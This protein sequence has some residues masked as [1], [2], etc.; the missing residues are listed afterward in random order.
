MW[1]LDLKTNNLNKIW[2]LSYSQGKD[3]REGR[4]N[5]TIGN[6]HQVIFEGI[7]GAGRGDIALDD[8]TISFSNCLFN[9]SEAFVNI[10]A[11]TT[12]PMLTTTRRLSNTTYSWLG[13]SDYDC[14]FENGFCNWKND[15][16]ADFN[17]T[18]ADGSVYNIFS[19]YGNIFIKLKKITFDNF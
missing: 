5:Y 8:L 4:F 16:K 15:L 14:N 13:Q 3:W 17:W 9:P 1:L 19:N 12:A 18:R 6:K 10:T 7:R 2:S 11:P